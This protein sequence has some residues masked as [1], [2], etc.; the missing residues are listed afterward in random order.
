VDTSEEDLRA[1]ANPG[2]AL[3]FSA[4]KSPKHSTRC[5]PGSTA[6]TTSPAS[7][8][9]RLVPIRGDRIA[10]ITGFLDPAMYAGFGLPAE[11]L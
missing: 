9:W 2:D 10:E 8:P 5:P 1:A 11:L 7:W 4:A 6:A 3:A